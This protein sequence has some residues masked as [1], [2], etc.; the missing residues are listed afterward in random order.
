M[1]GT[2]AVLWACRGISRTYSAV[3]KS[4]WAKTTLVNVNLLLTGGGLTK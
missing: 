4:N 1:L 3:V 2:F